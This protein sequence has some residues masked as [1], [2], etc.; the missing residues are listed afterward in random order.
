MGKKTADRKFITLISVM[1]NILS[2]IAINNSEPMVVIS[3]M[4]ASF[5][6]GPKIAQ[7]KSGPLDR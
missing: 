3:I 6:K 4:T 2:P 7:I 5:K 1:S